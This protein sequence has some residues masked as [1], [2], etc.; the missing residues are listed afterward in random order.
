[1]IYKEKK[2]L[3]TLYNALNGTDYQKPEELTVTTLENAIYFGMKNDV[4]F[5]LDSRVM[6]YEHQS[7]WNPNIPL[8]DAGGF[9]GESRAG[10]ELRKGQKHSC[11]VKVLRERIWSEEMNRYQAVP[12]VRA[13][14]LHRP[15]L[16]EPPRNIRPERFRAFSAVMPIPLPFSSAFSSY[17]PADGSEGQWCCRYRLHLSTGWAC[18]C[19]EPFCRSAEWSGSER[20]RCRK[21]LWQGWQHFPWTVR[22]SKCSASSFITETNWSLHRW[23]CLSG[24][25]RNGFKR[26]RGLTKRI[27][28]HILYNRLKKAW[29][30]K[31]QSIIR[32]QR[33]SVTG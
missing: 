13:D 2:E 18:T 20:S 19:G 29:N 16:M 31:K 9:P 21:A 5:L 24:C 32:P 27:F 6:L 12:S 8:R 25:L 4:S 33:G 17:A 28:L 23:N 14:D 10:G 11:R 1:M 7:T 30:G 15:G 22:R 26:D 3:L